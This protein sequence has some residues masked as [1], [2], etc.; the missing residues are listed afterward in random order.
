MAFLLIHRPR[1]FT[2]RLTC[3]WNG[4]QTLKWNS[5]LWTPSR[6][7]SKR[8]GPKSSTT[9]SK[10]YPIVLAQTPVTATVLTLLSPPPDSCENCTTKS[11]KRIRLSVWQK[12]SS[13]KP[14][15]MVLQS[16]STGSPS[17]KADGRKSPHG[18]DRLDF[19]T[20]KS[21]L[22]FRRVLWNSLT[23]FFNVYFSVRRCWKLRWGLFKT[24]TP[25][26][27]NF[28]PGPVKRSRYSSTSNTR[29]SL[30]KSL[31]LKCK[32]N[33]SVGGLCPQIRALEDNSTSLFYELSICLAR[34]IDEHTV[35]MEDMAKRTAEVDTV[36]KAK[37][38]K[39]R[40]QSTKKTSKDETR[41]ST[42][43]LNE[44]QRRQSIR[45]VHFPMTTL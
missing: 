14:T 15:Q 12:K 7:T 33:L 32:L 31:P 37:T 39:E 2:G 9:K 29:S 30:K 1:S 8:P 20:W 5:G 25:F 22:Q 18:P 42:Q 21:V 11:A 41:Q 13:P 3:S 28:W 16:S 27:L 24:W 19:V 43:E 44:I 36:I 26:W 34:L 35:F 23:P 45:Y 40:K 38:I 6:M 10:I 17:Y 4:S